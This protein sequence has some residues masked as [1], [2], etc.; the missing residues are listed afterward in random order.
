MRRPMPG[1]RRWARL[2]PVLPLILAP[3]LHCDPLPAGPG[4]PRPLLD[5]ET[6]YSAPFQAG[7]KLRYEV[8]WKPLFASPAFKAGELAFTVKR[9]RYRKRPAWTITMEAVSAGRL[10]EVARISVRNRFESIVDARN[11][12]SYRIFRE[13]REGKRKRDLLSVFDYGRDTAFFR[14]LDVSRDPPREL[15][16]RT[17]DGIPGPVTDLL[18]AIYVARL[19]RL[20]D[21]SRYRAHLADRGKFKEMLVRVEETERVELRVGAFD[22]VRLRVE[23]G[24]LSKGRTL[25]VWYSRDHLRV[26][27]K[28]EAEVKFGRVYGE[29]IGLEAGAVGRG[30]IRSR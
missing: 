9:S 3:A 13:H 25:R 12:H 20:E 29:L 14:D 30:L 10:V 5:R 16:N 19:Q 6:R 1:Y 27:V 4:T 8:N 18:S 21:G 28:F 22:T 17:S 15:H 26:P 2:L 7:E 11:F 23:E 24:I